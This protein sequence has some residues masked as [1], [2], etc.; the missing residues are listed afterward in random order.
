MTDQNKSPKIDENLY[1]RQIFVLG[2]DAMKKLAANSVLISGMGGLG[3][4]IAKNVILAGVKSV[5][6]QDTK[7]AEI[8]DLASNFYLTEK[9]IGKNR[10]IESLQQ[11]SSLNEYVTVD[12]KTEELTN[13][14]IKNYNCVVVTDYHSE[15]EINR[16]SK[17]C[18]ENFVMKITYLHI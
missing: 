7:N 16:I 3:V 14:F 10:A 18:H 8:N 11:L 2:I 4:E 9:S 15:T 17:F 5:T 13:D 6:I 12:A 1:S